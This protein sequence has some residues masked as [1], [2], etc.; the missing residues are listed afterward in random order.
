M[1]PSRKKSLEPMDVVEPV[2]D[3]GVAN[4]RLKQRNG[5]ID[6]VDNEFIERAAK[7]HQG[8]VAVA[9]MHDE[10]ADERIIIRRDGVAGVDGAIDAHAKAARRMVIGDLARRWPEG[11]GMLGIDPAFDRV[12]VKDD[13]VS[14]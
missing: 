6:S 14:G 5:R 7:P 2:L 4:Q 13:F 10:L 1:P 11:R 9:A 8:L 12:P 3:V